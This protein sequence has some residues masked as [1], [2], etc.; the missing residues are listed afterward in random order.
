MNLKKRD[1]IWVV[2]FSVVLLGLVVA[3]YWEYFFPE[4]DGYQLDFR[5][6]VAGRFG[7]QRA[8][9]VPSGIQQ[10]WIPAL[11]RTDRCPTCHLGSSWKGLDNAPEPYRSHPTA[12]LAKHPVSDFGCTVCHGGQGYG[13]TVAD[14]HATQLE[15]WDEPL[16]GRELGSIY[17]V[18]DRSAMDQIHCNLCHRY[19]R[20]T[21]G[22][23]Y[24]NTAKQ[25]VQQKGC[26]ACHKINGRGG[27][28]GPDLTYEGDQNAEQFDYSRMSGKPSV[29]GWHIAHFKD[30]KSMVATTVM[31]NF[32]F[33][34]R[35]AQSLTM[36][37]MSWKKAA[38]PVRYTPGV[39][40]ADLPTPEEAEKERQMLTGEG[41]FFVRKGCFICHDVTAFGVESAAKIGP[42]LSIAYS[43]VQSRFGRT[44][45][46]FL[47]APTGTMAVVLSTQIRLT[48][49]EREDAVKRLKDA[50][51]KHL[52][53]Q[54]QQIAGEKK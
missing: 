39:Q 20:Q 51:Q 45:E 36:L 43:D 25:L 21:Q 31:P 41:S 44:L 10:L 49:A 8:A 40:L 30:P 19:D 6:Y 16:L 38:L 27:V 33:G 12:I 24:I 7:E 23:S 3:L 18:S 26:R 53:D 15:H 14:A 34:S 47:R 50:Y 2:V 48:D 28:I 22:A 35:E 9:S 29:F 13:T 5:D 54:E 46:D 1:A 11:D 17:L 52:K 42:D 4:W 37:V 32:G